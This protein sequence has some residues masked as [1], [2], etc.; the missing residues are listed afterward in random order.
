MVASVSSRPDTAASREGTGPGATS[1]EDS[2]VGGGVLDA[3]PGTTVC[4]GGGI[5]SDSTQ[6]LAQIVEESSTKDQ[7][8]MMVRVPSG[9]GAVKTVSAE[10][11][12]AGAGSLRDPALT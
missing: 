12:D 1:V 5:V 4:D 3:A 9:N 8:V 10:R 2:G 7:E 11:A 6:L